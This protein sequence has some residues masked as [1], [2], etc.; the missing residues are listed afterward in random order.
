MTAPVLTGKALGHAVIDLVKDQPALHNQA[1]EI[2][3]SSACGT[4]ACLA[5]WTVLLGYGIT[6]EKARDDML[7]GADGFGGLLDA[8]EQT[9]ADGALE[10]LF[11]PENGDRNREAYD[12]FHN[13]VYNV[14]DR[15]RAIAHFREL[16]DQF[17]LDA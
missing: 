7:Y 12:R 5:G 1:V 3:D 15:L 14:A 2:D 8:G 16:V 17:G 10:L 11:G 6:P 13:E 4:V 9:A